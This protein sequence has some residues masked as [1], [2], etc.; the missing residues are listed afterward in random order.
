MTQRDKLANILHNAGVSA[1]THPTCRSADVWNEYRLRLAD[2]LI[3]R[4]IHLTN[5][6]SGRDEDMPCWVCSGINEHKKGCD[7]HLYKSRC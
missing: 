4:G 3:E 1:L 6:S 7:S 5:K 2:A